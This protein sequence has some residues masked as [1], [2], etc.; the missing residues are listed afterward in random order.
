MQTTQHRTVD[1][2]TIDALTIEHHNGWHP[3][4]LDAD[5][6]TDEWVC[7]VLLAPGRVWLSYQEAEALRHFA[8]TQG[9]GTR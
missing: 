5:G 2:A 7:R 4:E 8:H 3:E 9:E 1:P 6:W